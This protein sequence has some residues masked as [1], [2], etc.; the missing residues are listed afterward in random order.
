MTFSLDLKTFYHV[1]TGNLEVKYYDYDRRTGEISKP[2][3]FFRCCKDDGL[4]D[5][6]TIDMEGCLWLAFWNGGAIIRIS[7]AGRILRTI[8]LPAKIPTSVMFGGEGLKELFITTSSYGRISSENRVNEKG[9][10]LGGGIYRIVPGVAG[11]AEWPA[12][13]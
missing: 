13:F 8:R 9:E 7:P 1:E 10:F 6:L 11:R 5:G 12:D 3:E 4:P 2:R